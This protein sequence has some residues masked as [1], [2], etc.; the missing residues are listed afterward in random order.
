MALEPI[1]SHALSRWMEG[2]GPAADVCLSTRVR[3]ARNLRDLPFTHVASQAQLETVVRR[4]VEATRE[5]NKFGF[6]GKV[7][8]YRLADVPALERRVLVEKHLISPQ[9]AEDVRQ[10]ALILSQDETVSIMVNEEDHFRIQ[11]LFPALRLEEAWELAS[12]VDDALEQKLEL[13]FAD[14]MGYLTACPTNLGTGMRASLMMHLPGLV[15]TNQVGRVLHSASQLGLAVRGQYGEG[16]EAAGNIFQISNQ[17][18]LGRSEQEIVA[19]LKAVAGQIINQERHAREVLK[20]ESRPHLEDRIFRSYG[21][22]RNARIM[23]SE[24]AMKLFSDVRLGV[25]LGLIPSL[26]S[27]TL[28]EFLVITRPAYLQKQAGHELSAFDRDVRRATLI[29]ERLNG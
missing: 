12:R 7:E 26:S 18:T 1:V 21:L 9:H 13:A 16:T 10:K 19:H 6:L 28:N 17:V 20:S 2:S 23:T 8:M 11:C 24:E 15:L 14:E 4:A 29:R 25:D 3:L 27:R 22:L 5:L